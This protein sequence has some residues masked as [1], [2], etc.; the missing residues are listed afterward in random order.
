MIEVTNN[1]NIDLLF[2]IVTRIYCLTR[3]AAG[4]LVLNRNLDSQLVQDVLSKR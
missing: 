4:I 1:M 3:N 2:I